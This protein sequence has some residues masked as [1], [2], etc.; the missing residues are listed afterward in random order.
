M[1]ATEIA[2][3]AAA[4]MGGDRERTHGSKMRNHANIAALWNAYLSIRRDPASP[5]SAGDVAHMMA[6]LKMARSQL[7][8]VNIDD[9][10][11]GAAYFCIAG[12]IE[13]WAADR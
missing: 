3:A 9:F 10:T 6:L 4:L 8:A 5:L 7:G 13:T 1:K 12:E 2:A 11:D